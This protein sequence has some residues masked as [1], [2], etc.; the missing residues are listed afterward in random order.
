M[1]EYMLNGHSENMIANI[2]LMA[3]IAKRGIA[4]KILLILA[5]VAAA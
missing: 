5:V 2:E 3:R 1:L 4:T